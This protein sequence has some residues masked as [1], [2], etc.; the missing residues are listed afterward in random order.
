LNRSGLEQVL[1]KGED[2]Y[3]ILQNVG[4]DMALLVMVKKDPNLGMI[5]LKM[6]NI[7]EQITELFEGRN[8]NQ[9]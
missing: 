8:R 2:G 6:K 4:K 3:I 9:I 5:L 1:L 7:S